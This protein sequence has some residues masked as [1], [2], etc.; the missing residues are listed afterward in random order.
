MFLLPHELPAELVVLAIS[1]RLPRLLLRLR[2][3]SASVIPPVPDELDE[4]VEAADELSLCTKLLVD[5][6]L[7]T[8]FGWIAL[9]GSCLLRDSNWL[10]K[11]RTD[12]RNFFMRRIVEKFSSLSS[13]AE[14][15]L[16]NSPR[17]LVC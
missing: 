16:T 2:L 10:R 8:A 6:H 12:G 1:S 3:R 14:W 11:S 7:R 5:F 9:V 17:F 13:F 4:A 15:T